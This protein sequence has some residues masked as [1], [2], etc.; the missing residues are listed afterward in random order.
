MGSASAIDRTRGPCSNGSM[1]RDAITSRVYVLQDMQ[2]HDYS[3]AEVFGQ[4][5]FVSSDDINSR[6]SIVGTPANRLVVARL[7]AVLREFREGDFLV[8]DGNPILIAIA[9][10]FLVT[11]KN[12]GVKLL[13]WDNR[14]HDYRVTFYS[15][16]IFELITDEETR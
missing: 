12:V 14:A 8:V 13:K 16:N 1:T 2:G 3:P 15:A 7:F 9:L 4:L 11:V 6:L 10:Q 5:V